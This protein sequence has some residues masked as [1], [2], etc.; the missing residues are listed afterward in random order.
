[1]HESD[2]V[3]SD[4]G[5]SDPDAVVWVRGVDYAAGWRAAKD[6]AAELEKALTAAG[7]DAAGASM[8]AATRADGSGVV[9]LV[10]PVETVR[11][12]ARLLEDAGE[13]KRAG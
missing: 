2:G 9:R 11:T 10:W 1:M 12:V 7:V 13:L 5:E 6:A 8:S 3:W 4:A